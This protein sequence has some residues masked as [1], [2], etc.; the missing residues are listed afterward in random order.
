MVSP[1]E[2]TSTSRRSR[3]AAARTTASPSAA[4]S[5]VPGHSSTATLCGRC[6]SWPRAAA[7]VKTSSVASPEISRSTR[8]RLSW[9]LQLGQPAFVGELGSQHQ[10]GLFER[11][12]VR[13]RRPPVRVDQRDHAEQIAGHLDGDDQ[14]VPVPD[15]AGPA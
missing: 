1:R 2:P 10:R 11:R 3:P 15:G 5:A 13:F 9:W 8:S 7:W 4:L 14:P 6:R 12:G